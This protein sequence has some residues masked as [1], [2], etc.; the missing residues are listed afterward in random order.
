MD[1]CRCYRLAGRL[2]EIPFLHA[3]EHN[4]LTTCCIYEHSTLGRCIQ[5]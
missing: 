1:L 2:Q 4:Q 5:N 3:V